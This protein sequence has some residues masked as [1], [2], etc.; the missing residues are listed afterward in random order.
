ME[1]ESAIRKRPLGYQGR[2]RETCG[3]A[4]HAVVAKLLAR[5]SLPNSISA[6]DGIGIRA[7][8]RTEILWVR[9]P[10]CRLYLENLIKS[11]L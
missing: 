10:P 6:C 2:E 3:V 4:P 8:L 7:R 5:G 11:M 1:A 9:I